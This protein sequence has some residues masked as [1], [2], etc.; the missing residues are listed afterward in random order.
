M[1]RIRTIKPEMWQS[2]E[3]AQVSEAAMLLAIGLLNHADDEGYFKAN[4]G[5]VKAAVF[6]LREPSMNIHGML[7]ELSNA[8]YLELFE[9]VDGKQYGF[10]RNF[11]KDQKINRPSPSKIN[12]LRKISENSVNDHGGLTPGKERKGME[13]KYNSPDESG[14]GYFFEGETIRLNEAD[15][16]KLKSQYS[17]LD[18][19][20]QLGQLDLELRGKKN[21]FVEMNSKL[22]YRN[23]T[24]AHHATL[25]I[26]VEMID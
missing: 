12:E 8:R 20:Y 18:L 26:S 23:K 22:N 2:E 15:Y 1:A 24:P 11:T 10:I 13:R 21:W 25:G 14:T 9:G 3:L 17:N 19:E 5:L 6:P 7:T 16:R 4:P